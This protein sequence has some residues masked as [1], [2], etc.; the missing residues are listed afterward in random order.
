MVMGE[1]AQH[2]S[3]RGMQGKLSRVRV[4]P[5]AYET[6]VGFWIGHWGHLSL[7]FLVYNMEVVQKHIPLFTECSGGKKERWLCQAA[8]SAAESA[9][10]QVWCRSCQGWILWLSEYLCDGKKGHKSDTKGKAT[11]CSTRKSQMSPVSS[12]PLLQLWNHINVTLLRAGA[13]QRSGQDMGRSYYTFNKVIAQCFILFNPSNTLPHLTDE[14][15]RSSGR[16][17]ALPKVTLLGGEVWKHTVAWHNCP[18][19]N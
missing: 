4:S 3:F 18:G 10:A 19:G 15:N 11:S 6:P 2:M 13:S 9:A 5:A 7:S 1:G 17:S 14:E 8:N 12:V 16:L